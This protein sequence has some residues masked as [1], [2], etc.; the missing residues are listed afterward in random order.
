MALF[1]AI[2]GSAVVPTND[3]LTGRKL[4]RLLQLLRDNRGCD[5]VVQSCGHKGSCCDVHDECYRIYGCTQSSWF[6]MCKY[7]SPKYLKYISLFL[8]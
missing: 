7:T 3:N 1:G 6:S 4:D 2:N 8:L 5:A